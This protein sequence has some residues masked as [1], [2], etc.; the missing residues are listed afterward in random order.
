MAVKNI[1]QRR[2]DKYTE[3]L[4]R[5]EKKYRNKLRDPGFRAGLGLPEGMPPESLAV[6]AKA[7][8]MR[9]TKKPFLPAPHAS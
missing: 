3:R 9:N 4:A 2:M 7:Q 8:A 6:I 1:H 5:N